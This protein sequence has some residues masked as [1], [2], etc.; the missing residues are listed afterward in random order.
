MSKERLINFYRMMYKIRMF[1]EICI[2]LKLND[3]IMDGFH[4]YQGQ[5]AVAVGVCSALENTDYVLSTHRPQGHALAKG[6]EP[7]KV[8]AEMAGRLGGIG[9]GKG[10]PM[11]FCDWPNRFLCTSIVGDGIP[12]S[13]GLGLAIKAKKR[14]EIVVS[15]FGDG[16]TNTGAFHEGLNLASIWNLPILFV[17]ENNQ[18]TEATPISKAVRIEKLS[19]RS[20][21]YGIEGVTINGDDIL[22]IYDTAT[23]MVEKIRK[24]EGPI[25][26]EI[27][28]Y[29]FRGHYMGDPEN[30]RTKEEVEEWK[31]KDPIPKF[32]NYLLET[33]TCKEEEINT[34]EKNIREEMKGIKEWVLKQPIPT[35]EIL[36]RNVY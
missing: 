7:R 6:C 3:I 27:I 10:G 35:L 33:Q 23:K 17:C 24:G 15:F 8:L 12:L 2:D 20:M 32:R 14:K 25:L 18:Y 1:D 31:K 22:N 28:T 19:T 26:L 34:I 29:R 4:P 36:T 16:A 5:E 21:S 9:N 11:N 13:T 30:Y